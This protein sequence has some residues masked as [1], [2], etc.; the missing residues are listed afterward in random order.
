M[1]IDKA[2]RDAVLDGFIYGAS[3]LGICSVIGGAAGVLAWHLIH[4]PIEVQIIVCIAMA[5]A[6]YSGFCYGKG[7]LKKAR[8]KEAKEA[9]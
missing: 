3:L 1:K 8:E 6:V 7:Q 9:E 4:G 5:A 2:F